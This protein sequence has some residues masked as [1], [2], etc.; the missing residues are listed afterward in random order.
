MRPTAKDLA[1]AAG[2][3]LA[4]VDRV[5][6]ERPNVSPKAARKVA[7]AIE[8]IGFVRNPAAVALARNKTYR[9]RFVL[10]T[11]G[12]QYLAELLARVREAKEALRADSTEVEA[13]Q[14]PMSDPHHVAK[15]L[16]AIDHDAV[17]GVAVMAP[18]SPQVRDALLRLVERG[19]KVVQFLSG[20]ERLE[21]AD[22]VG[23][24]NFAAGATAGKIAGRFIGARPGKIMVVAETMMALDS[25]QRR[26]GF[27]SIINAQF[28]H[29]E[30][31][32]SLETYADEKRADLIIRRTLQHNPDT[33]AVY[34]LSSEAR[35][36]LSAVWNAQGDRPLTVI[37]HEHTPFSAQALMDER[38]DAVIAQDPGHAVRSALRIMRARADHRELLAS[39]ERIRI[40]VLLKENLPL[41]K[42]AG[43]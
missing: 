40:E 8:R 3:S 14:I 12:D 6:N 27:D 43:L 42:T 5:L 29:L 15:Y 22:Y 9:F 2:V 21:S 18:E 41:R 33:V 1:E 32:P 37:A 23:I 39:Q 25:I 13:V 35:V 24:D 19:V 11:S 17:D 34:V 7:E 20:Q 36:P 4:T 16:T 31:L 38:I 10:P 28:P 30:S 26:L